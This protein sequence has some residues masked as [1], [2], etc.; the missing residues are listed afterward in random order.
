MKK[1][2]NRKGEIVSFDRNKVKN[3]IVSAMLDTIDGVDILLAEDITASIEFKISNL[4]D[5]NNIQNLILKALKKESL[6]LYT[7]Y[8]DYMLYKNKVRYDNLNKYKILTNSFI[9]KYKHK[10]TNMTPLGEF[11]YYRT[12]SRWL[13]NEKRREKWYETVR[14]AIEF[15]CSLGILEEGE[16]ENLYD[17]VFNLKQFC[18]GRTFWVGNTEVSKK[19]PMANYNCAGLV[20]NKLSDFCDLFYLLLLGCGVGCRILK[21]DVKQILNLNTTY[22]LNH[23]YNKKK[24]HLRKDETNLIKKNNCFIIE[25]GDS[26]E[27]WVNTLRHFLNIIS[28]KIENCSI[29]I[30][31]SNIREKGEELKTF[32]GTASGYEALKSIFVKLNNILKSKNKD[33]YNL[34]SLDCLDICNII[35]E[36]V[37][38]GGVRRT[39]EIIIFDVDDIECIQAKKDL[40]QKNESNEWKINKN[41][42]HRQM[43]NNSIMYKQKPTREQLHWNIQQLRNTGEPG[44]IN[45]TSAS[46]RRENFEILNPCSEVLLDTQQLCNLTTV[47]VLGFVQNG[48][49]NKKELLEAQRLSA[50]A[51]LRMT[52]LTLELEEWDKKQK[53]DS[54]IGCSL[55]G[56]QDMINAC[57]MT[58]ENQKLLLTDLRNIVHKE[59]KK[60][61]KQL[62]ISEPILSTT[63]KP[64]GSLSQLP[65]VSSGLHYSHS[66]YCIRRVRINNNDPLLKVCEE[67]GYTIN[68]EVGQN[69]E[70]C[71]TKVVDF[72]IKSTIGKTKEDITAIEQ[73]ECYKMFQTYY[74]DHNS[75]ITITVKNDEWSQV[76]E[77]I[78]ENWDY[79]VGISLLS[80]D[81]SVYQLMPYEKITKEQYEQNQNKKF[82]PNL[83]K[84]YEK[85]QMDLDIG[86][87][88]CSNGICPIR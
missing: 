14:R 73:L 7:T 24:K 29:E 26:K 6:E 4:E 70:N 64:E 21:D 1:I 28:E 31:Y 12:Y 33:L 39:A 18:S 19:F 17:N 71:N 49:L 85:I 16:A 55:T 20:I 82:V 65:T 76:E 42:I 68:T 61:S 72:Y 59:I 53:R 32:G 36:T 75:S 78:W 54:L 5:I 83:L 57:N 10:T 84:K 80:Y 48:K 77:W 35:G 23:T 60:Y 27:G 34:S 88:E 69:E 43:S 2:I 40:Y 79:I 66:E 25:V 37:V 41:I 13:D 62:N 67:L 15:N 81:D 50:R 87:S 58:I 9:S 22:N 63:I 52:C 46:I 86:D 47:N 11:V 38:V 51:G 3:A 74:T 30:D 44:F 56:W 45:Y 8:K